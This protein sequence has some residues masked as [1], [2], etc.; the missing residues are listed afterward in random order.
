[1][2][3]L[4][5]LHARLGPARHA[6]LGQVLRFGIV[7]LVG[8][9]VDTAVLYAALALGMGPYGGRVLSYLAAAT[10]NWA[11]NRAWTFRQGKAAAPARQWALF[12][13]VNLLG[14]ALNY[15]VYALL[16]SQVATVAQHPALGVAAGAVVGMAGNFMLSR[17]LVFGAT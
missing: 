15:G 1:M 4:R 17:R 16:V 5:S 8:L 12:L 6:L 11:L 2:Q 3:A 7:G 13:A 10:G 14:F 9:V